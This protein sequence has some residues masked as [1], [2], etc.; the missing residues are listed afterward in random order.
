MGNDRI[1]HRTGTQP[2]HAHSGV[3]NQE[4][5][6]P[7]GLHDC[8]CSQHSQDLLGVGASGGGEGGEGGL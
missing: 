6:V 5:R 8:T 2:V 3:W 1:R 4:G 7:N